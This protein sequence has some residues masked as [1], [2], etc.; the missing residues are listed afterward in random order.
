MILDISKGIPTVASIVK[1][2]LLEF[3]FAVDH[4][5]YR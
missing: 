2:E 4:P 5:A 3:E 1:L